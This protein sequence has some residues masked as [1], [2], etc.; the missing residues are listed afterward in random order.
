MTANFLGI[1][2]GSVSLNLFLSMSGS[3]EPLTV[4]L[5]TKGRPLLT[6]IKALDQMAD[7]LG[8]DFRLSGVLVTGSA[9]ELLA[10]ALGISAINEINAHAVGAHKVNPTIRTIIEIG[11]QDSK[12]IRI[13]KSADG[14]MPRVPVFRMNEICAAGTGAFL[15]EQAERLGIPIESFGPLALQSH[16]PASIAGRCAVFAKTD[17]IHQAQEGTPLPDILMGLAVALVRNYEATLI[18]GD[19]PEPIV[20]L[21]GGV[22]S[23]PAIV[24]TFRQSL[25][26]SPEQVVVPPHFK[27]LGAL[28]C[29]E[30]AARRPS[31]K[32]LSLG[33]LKTLAQQAAHEPPGRSFFPPLKRMESDGP[34]NTLCGNDPLDLQRPLILGLDVGS[35]SAKGVIIDGSGAIVREDYRLSKSRPLEAVGGVLQ[36]L[37]EGDVAPDA[38]CVTGSGRYL[39]GRLLGADIIVNEITAQARAALEGDP[40]VDTVVEIGGQDSKWIAFEEGRVT[41]FD[42]N[43]VCAAGTGSFLMAQA[44]RLDLYMGEVYSE[45][46]FSSKAPA[47]LGNR[48]TVFMESDLIHH[49]NNGASSEDLAAGVCISIV[50]NYL[51]RVANHKA[52]GNKV[53]FLGGVA[54]TPAVKAAF[55]QYTGRGFHVPPF[56]RVSGALGAALTGADKIGRGEIKTEHRREIQW[57]PEEIEREQFNCKGCTNQ[58]KVNKLQDRRTDRVSRGPLR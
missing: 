15:D 44:Q 13:E 48:C 29:A 43:R 11:G 28:G 47:D 1:D 4:Y 16:K 10:N 21:Q 24:H 56:F 14:R 40:S 20:S 49:Q 45:A 25:K 52:L 18:R 2:C 5:R 9:R 23:N 38:I 54:A 50:K 19:S 39:A 22:M 31:L 51:E 42:M 46:A 34:C 30:L 33:E 53:L 3:H 37:L 55:E 17:M 26:L 27:V 57:N 41:D 8:G 36:S 7:D 58:C 35:V 6:F 12:Y 32:R